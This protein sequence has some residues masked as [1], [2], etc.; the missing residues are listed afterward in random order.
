MK[1][2]MSFLALALTILLVSLP[3]QGVRA[4]SDIET[5]VVRV[6]ATKIAGYYHKPWKSPNFVTVRGS[7]FFFKDEKDFP[8]VR[9]LIL[10]NAHAVS[11]AESIKISNG[12]E[13]RRYGAKCIGIFNSADFAVLRLEPKE[14]EAYERRNGKIQPLE[15]GDSD[16]LRLGDK[17]LGW[18]YPLGG[19]RISK[20]EEG[21]INR[22]EVNRYA[23]SHEHWLMVQASLQQNRGN[24]GGPVLKEGKVVGIAFQGMRATDRIN[25]F[26]PINLV[27]SLFP[28]L[29]GKQQ[30]TS[31]RYKVQYMF[32]E[33]KAYFNQGPDDGGVLLDY[34]IPDGGPYRFGL[35]V[36]DILL[37]IDD[38]EI[39]NHGDIFFRPLQQRIFAGEILNR[40]K[41]GDPLKLSV[42]R[43]GKRIEITG[44]VT[45][46][47]PKLVPR[48]FRRAN[49]FIFGG[50]GFVELTFN[51][52]TN[53]GKSGRT[54]R[55]KYL[56]EFPKKPF[57]KIV[58][59]SEVFPE[60]GLVKTRP[61]LKRVE[62]INGEDVLNITW[63]FDKIQELKSKGAKK[64]MLIITGDVRLPLDFERAEKLDAMI[65]AK[66]GILYM[67]TPSGFK[68]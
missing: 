29:L 50:I 9:G 10:T 30:I 57:Q 39:D 13:K 27:K 42:I 21:E 63:L 12:R 65:K 67:K 6:N 17:V 61:Y 1:H 68:E 26:I 20:S 51:C 60:Y 37:A 55:A 48:A 15:L 5:K 44:K 62:K 2:Y 41:V 18:G 8:N 58:I 45:R 54:F 33:L 40:K 28:V 16:T 43:N 23:Y 38:H 66:Y 7:G 46:G 52:I 4:N 25:Y 56:A 3:A 64:A 22:I 34:I 19:E 11:M 32:P 47:L 59:V 31:W 35:R 53:L 49:Y 36:G 24:S 14:L